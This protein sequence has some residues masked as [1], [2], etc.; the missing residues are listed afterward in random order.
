[1]SDNSLSTRI[2]TFVHDVLDAL[3][4]DLDVS[5]EQL[6]D[7]V[8]VNIEGE[9]A[10][11]LLKRKGE[12]L[13]ALQQIA[14][15]VFRREFGEG[16]RLVVD[17]LGFRRAKDAELRQMAKFLIEKVKT[18]G[19]PQELGPLNSYAR[20]LVHLEVADAGGV[21]SESLGDGALKRVVISPGE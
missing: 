11:V 4:L 14:S 17:C 9:Q 18:S 10:N 1:M 5:L 15:M 21:T 16:R 7:G 6:E 13:D 20:R 8:R 19:I 2:E 12:P 3:G